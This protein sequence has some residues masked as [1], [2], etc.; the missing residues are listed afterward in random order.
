MKYKCNVC[1]TQ[2]DYCTIEEP[3]GMRPRICPFYHDPNF[4][5]PKWVGVKE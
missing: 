2:N 1:W 5:K 3:A 4:R